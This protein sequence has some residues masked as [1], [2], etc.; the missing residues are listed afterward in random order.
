MPLPSLFKQRTESRLFS[1]YTEQFEVG[2]QS[3]WA[4]LSA[5]EQKRCPFGNRG[6]LVGRA[7]D[8]L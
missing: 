4:L 7:K 2:L 3:F 5:G 6:C 8:M 1:L